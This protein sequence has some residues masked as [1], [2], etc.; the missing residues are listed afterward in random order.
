MPQLILNGA[1]TAK[2]LEPTSESHLHAGHS[3]RSAVS[4]HDRAGLYG[5][6]GIGPAASI[7]TTGFPPRGAPSSWALFRHDV[8]RLVHQVQ[9]LRNPGEVLRSQEANR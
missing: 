7:P 9:R 3:L 5:R 4:V 8:N 2:S 1:C 6:T